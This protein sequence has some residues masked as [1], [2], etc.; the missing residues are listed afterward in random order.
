MQPASVNAQ[1]RPHKTMTETPRRTSLNPAEFQERQSTLTERI[2]QYDSPTHQRT[3]PVFRES[4]HD[5]R[6]TDAV[7]VIRIRIN[8]YRVLIR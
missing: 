4:A 7:S 8:V 1:A 6:Q 5:P 2:K 3:L